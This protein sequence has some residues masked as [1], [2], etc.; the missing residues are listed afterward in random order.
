MA[1]RIDQHHIVGSAKTGDHRQ[2]GLVAC[3]EN[4]AAA[5][6]KQPR[7]LELEIAMQ[8]ERSA[9]DARSGR[10]RA[11]AQMAPARRP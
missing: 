7:E 4:R 11:V 1:L 6:F 3:R 8:T 9:G 2:V 10:R 5:L